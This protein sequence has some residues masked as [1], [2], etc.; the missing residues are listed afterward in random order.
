M[1]N[2]LT[3]NETEKKSL[4]DQSEKRLDSG[5]SSDKILAAVSGGPDSM[6]MLDMLCKFGIHGFS[7]LVPVVCHVN[8]HHRPTAGRDERIVRDYCR[9]HSIKLHVL[10]ADPQE[11]Q[12]NF[13]AW[14]RKLRYDF[15]ESVGKE[16]NTNYLLCAHQQDDEIETYLMQKK[17]GSI[18][19]SYGLLEFSAHGNL[20]VCRP[21]LERTKKELQDYCDQNQVPYGID[22]SNLQD[23]Y[24]RNRIRHQIVEKLSDGE[25]KELLSR[26]KEDN[27]KL[28]NEKKRIHQILKEIPEPEIWKNEEYE[29]LSWRILDQ[30]IADFCNIHFSKESLQE[31]LRQLKSSGHFELWSSDPQTQKKSETNNSA[32]ALV[33]RGYMDRKKGSLELDMEKK[34]PYLPSE[35]HENK[36][37]RTE[38]R[39]AENRESVF[40][41]RT[42]D[43]LRQLC[44]DHA[45]IECSNHYAIEFTDHPEKIESFMVKE[46][47]FPI[48]I[49]FP[50]A[51]EKIEL[52]FGSKKVSRILMDRQI[53]ARFRK[54]FPI[55]RNKQEKVIFMPLT[56]CDVS[57]FKE[58]SPFGMVLFS[59]T[60]SEQKMEQS[61]EKRGF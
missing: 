4:K 3:V 22:E 11:V 27:R 14:A 31:A 20:I 18:P 58:N 54:G 16:E 61:I 60:N 15:F 49:A 50:L 47:D 9:K 33:I 13:Q 42:M 59:L 12:G 35:N 30:K 23:D 40:E 10:E 48:C 2:D 39:K 25:R 46:E 52:R 45:R 24:E 51:G 19:S 7:G 5:K 29:K 56:G 41:I 6:A 38:N 34:Q 28:E 53:P 57:H 17:R 36:N 43:E 55:L 21:L 32:Q 8:Y 26:I 37:S 1:Q 44:K